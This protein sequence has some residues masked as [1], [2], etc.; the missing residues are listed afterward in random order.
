MSSKKSVY[1]GKRVRVILL[2]VL[3][4]V[5]ACTGIAIADGQEK[6]P[7]L[8]TINGGQSI[9]DGSYINKDYGGYPFQTSF[10]LTEE[11]IPLESCVLGVE[12]YD[13]DEDASSYWHTDEYDMVYVNGTFVGVLTGSDNKW[14]TT[15]MNVP[16]NVFKT[17]SNTVTIYVG[18]K[19]HDTGE[20]VRDTSDWLLTVKQLSLKIDGGKSAIAP[21]VFELQLQYASKTTAGIECGAIVVI[22]SDV[23]RTYVIEY[24][25][26]DKT[27]SGSTNNQ[28]I[29][30]DTD[31]VNGSSI[32]STGVFFLDSS[33]PMGT[34][35][36]QATLRDPVTNEMYAH[37]SFTFDMESA[38]N[39]GCDHVAKS[40]STYQS[41]EYSRLLQSHVA[42]EKEHRCID[43]YMATCSKCNESFT[44]Y[45]NLR[46]EAHVTPCCP[47]GYVDKSY[48]AISSVTLKPLE[49]GR[50]GEQFILEIITDGNVHRMSA[51]NNLDIALNGHW[52]SEKLGNGTIRWFQIYTADLPA[53]SRT[54]TAQAFNANGIPIGKMTSD[55][56]VIKEANSASILGFDMHVWTG[57][58]TLQVV[59]ATNGKP[60]PNAGVV[61]YGQSGTT[62][63]DGKVVF[64]KADMKNGGKKLYIQANHYNM[65]SEEEYKLGTGGSYDVIQMYPANKVYLIPQSCNGEN[66]NTGYS[67]L[68]RQALL[69]AEIKL[70]ASIHKGDKVLRYE[71]LQN[72]AVIA[73]DD[74]GT[75]I[76]KVSN[77][78]FMEGVP[79][80]ARMVVRHSDG[81]E[82]KAE[83]KL[84]IVVVS[85]LLPMNANELPLDQW[86]GGNLALPIRGLPS[87]IGNLEFN[88]DVDKRT[89][90]MKSSS[91]KAGFDGIDIGN[92][93][94]VAKIGGSTGLTSKHSKTYVLTGKEKRW[95]TGK[96]GE[97]TVELVFAFDEKG[98]YQTTGGAG[99]AFGTS[100]EKPFNTT[101]PIG[102]VVIP[103]TASLDV[104]GGVGLLLNDIG[105]NWSTQKWVS[106]DLTGDFSA[107][108]KLFGGVGFDKSV[109]KAKIGIYGKVGL[110]AELGFTMPPNFAGHGNLTVDGEL[111]FSV[112]LKIAFVSWSEDWPF[113]KGDI[114]KLTIGQQEPM[115]FMLLYAQENTELEKVAHRFDHSR[116]IAA[117][118]S[119][120]SG[121]TFADQKVTLSAEE[122]YAT[123]EEN[124]EFITDIQMVSAG[125]ETIMVYGV[126][127]NES[128]SGASY[129]HLVFRRWE[130]QDWS[131]PV[132]VHNS[133][134]P[135]GDFSLTSDGETI[136][137]ACL[138]SKQA[139]E[140]SALENLPSDPD[141]LIEKLFD[142]LISPCEI[143]VSRYNL[144][145]HGFE[146]LPA[147]TSDMYYDDQPSIY[148]ENGQPVVAWVKN[149]G[150]AY[151]YAEQLQQI[152]MATW[153]GQAWQTKLLAENIPTVEKIVLGKLED[154][155]HIALCTVEVLTEDK[156]E[157]AVRLV[158]AS[159]EVAEL[160]RGMVYNPCFGLAGNAPVLLWY[161]SG[162]IQG[163]KNC[164]EAPVLYYDASYGIE[165]DFELAADSRRSYL[166]CNGQEENGSNLWVLDLNSDNSEFACVTDL[167][168]YVNDFETIVQKNS[169]FFTLSRAD[170]VFAEDSMSVTNDLCTAHCQYS[171]D[172][173]LLALNWN[174]E[175]I[176]PGGTATIEAQIKNLGTELVE[177]VVLR[178]G[179]LLEQTEK[180]PVAL[181]CGETASLVFELDLPADLQA[182]EIQIRVTLPDEETQ[183]ASG[184][185]ALDYTDL[186]VDARQA[187]VAKKNCLLYTVL[188]LGPVG[189][190]AT[191]S[192]HLG[193]E[194]GEVVWS[195]AV[196]L[197]GYG[198][199][200]D[201][202]DIDEI[203]RDKAMESEVFL[204]L[205]LDMPEADL[206]VEN[207][208]VRVLIRGI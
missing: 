207:N 29:A 161:A 102:P 192:L 202:I 84:N 111:G 134:L 7:A 30:D 135:E 149:T 43:V 151:S 67:Q 3:V 180:V 124:V 85:Q 104:K 155:L 72:N 18:H 38:L 154:G 130:G 172:V 99:F 8:L 139:I 141:A 114:L 91:A 42:Y 34:Y 103:L 203:C 16:V 110:L 136:Y 98:V 4:L 170:V 165:P 12:S 112:D 133:N 63:N 24:S 92:Y 182:G 120:T 131:E 204:T 185:I 56:I 25:L 107:S 39:G 156:V 74:K 105:Y 10:E 68:N 83:E 194:T 87:F 148:L 71:L 181:V 179:G 2:F 144:E 80:V 100:F 200:N 89:N 53:K 175:E 66:I 22:E 164:K 70:G 15:Y 126:S 108:V 190:E 49:N 197:E 37:D 94:I 90:S 115:Y 96:N 23:P 17:G 153:D 11:S 119:F 109:F 60:I 78:S 61:L 31:Q 171:Q 69:K 54:W 58:Y 138:Q 52:E 150:D 137:L 199:E 129:G 21:E 59:D 62:G 187:V 198:A 19:D 79:V 193:D 44:T 184:I 101:V 163:I 5:F 162:E 152:H 160:E 13:C 28:I 64:Q 121:V 128:Q 14:K 81:R 145:T 177:E 142:L 123:L 55:S 65:Y 158:D 157:R 36:I 32:T 106:P 73:T 183:G 1:P 57:S 208:Q 201:M 173:V 132:P 189:G 75:G 93:E 40:A 20:I 45:R 140:D 178:I 174:S 50:A 51:V 166:I 168:G 82:T 196:K 113:L 118:P 169:L 6:H 26:V 76:L 46:N 205:T 206:L 127:T 146:P 48:N 191:L 186:Y 77:S 116:L 33:I 188:N 117:N 122:P 88:F 125:D 195:R 9:G 86:L 159:G 35:E 143:A 95:E 41:T 27:G 147:V 167:V 97:V 176:I 47:C